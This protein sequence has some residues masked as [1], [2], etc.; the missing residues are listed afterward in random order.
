MVLTKKGYDDGYG[1]EVPD[2][3]VACCVIGL[4]GYKAAYNDQSYGGYGGYG[5]YNY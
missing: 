1:R 3:L 4:S 5:G 2:E